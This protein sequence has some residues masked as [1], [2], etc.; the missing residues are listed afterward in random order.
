MQIKT[1]LNRVHKIKGFVYE[2]V[3]FVD[4]GIEVEVR[5]RQGSRPYC[6]GCGRQGSTYDHLPTRRFAFVP[7]W[8]ICVYLVYAMRR[9]S[10]PGCHVKV[11]RVPWA[12]GKCHLTCAFAVFL[13][14]WARKLSWKET[15]E[16]FHTSATVEVST[17]RSGGFVVGASGVGWSTIA[18]V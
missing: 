10:C 6:S 1:V 12:E 14:R 15:A 4:D 7:I 9:V 11:E 3:R 13:A 17:S 2:G 18:Q 5:S 8:G 16:S